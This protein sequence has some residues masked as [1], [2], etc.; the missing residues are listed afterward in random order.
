MLRPLDVALGVSA[1]GAP[2]Y[3]R[4][5]LVAAQRARVTTILVSCSPDCPLGR[6]VDVH[7]APDTGAEVLAGS[8]R[9][10]AGT[11]TKLVLNAISTTAMIRLGRTY[12]N[13]MVGLDPTNAKLQGRARRIL[14]EAAGLGE[15]EAR[16]LLAAASGEVPTAL[17]MALAG[18]GA[19]RARAA[20]ADGDGSVRRAL[21]RLPAR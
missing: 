10:K 6:E 21:T 4:G 18:V 14:R 15:E 1:S 20:L 12:G 3:V 9:L 2:P 17:V 16:E 11:A 8:T 5:A 13:L 19:G 7:V